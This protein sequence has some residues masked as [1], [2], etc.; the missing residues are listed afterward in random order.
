M[1]SAGSIEAAASGVRGAGWRPDLSRSLFLLGS[2][3]LALHPAQWLVNTWRDPSYGSAGLPIAGLTLALAVW[4]LSSARVGGAPTPW[5][6]VAVLLGI[7]AAARLAGQVLGINILG[8]LALVVDVYALALLLGLEQRQRPISP[9]WLCV[10]FAFSLPLERVAQRTIG[11][12]LQ[13]ISAERSCRLLELAPHPVRC[14]GVRMVLNGHDV[15]VDLPCSGARGLLLL[16]VSFAALAAI[17][18]PGRMACAVGLLLTVVAGLAANTVRISTLAVGIAYQEALGGVDVMAPAWHEG[19][20]LA[21]L[22]LGAVPLYLWFR[23]CVCES[24]LRLPATPSA[25]AVHG[26][27]SSRRH[28]ITHLLCAAGFVLLALLILALP[29]RPLDVASPDPQLALPSHL[30]GH[31]A[32]HD[33]LSDRERDYFVRYGGAARRAHYGPHGLLMVRTSAPLRHL[34]A[35]DECLRGAGHRV[36]YLGQQHGQLPA[37]VYRSESPDGRSWRIEV[38]YVS[39][40]G[41]LATSIAQAVWQWFG[42]PEERWTMVQRVTPWSLSHAQRTE[43]DAALARSLDRPPSTA[44]P[45]RLGVARLPA[46]RAGAPDPALAPI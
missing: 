37:A 11:F 33:D 46:P 18:R 31:D 30:A 5:R 10:I 21:T 35:P 38:S 23:R 1:H 9:F 2:L 42:T 39:S 32:I 41:A 15:L 36:R 26:P 44:R 8:A 3:V 14:E 7:T 34:H 17:A 28:G 19:I 27:S 40:S 16:M 45:E 25:S 13:Q 29:V 6:K 22:A 24:R 20:G 4:S 12:P 43:F